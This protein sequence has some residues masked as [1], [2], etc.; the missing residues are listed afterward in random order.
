MRITR[1]RS[2]KRCGVNPGE[3]E[4]AS[5]MQETGKVLLNSLARRRKSFEIYL[6]KIFSSISLS[7]EQTWRIV[8]TDFRVNS[9]LNLMGSSSVFFL[10]SSSNVF[11]ISTSTTS[12]ARKTTGAREEL[13]SCVIKFSEYKLSAS[14]VYFS[15][16]IPARCL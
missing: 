6:F 4:E 5:Q 10:C 2:R 12:E 9:V 14:I 8:R 11:D 15:I 1:G 16:F 3:K 7:L 13:R